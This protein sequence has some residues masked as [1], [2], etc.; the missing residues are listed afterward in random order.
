MRALQVDPKDN[1]AVVS[2]QT[3]AGETVQAGQTSLTAAEAVPAG[4]KI[5]LEDIPAGGMVVKYGV[6]IGRASRDIPAGSHVHSHN[7]EDITSQLCREYARAF[8]KKAG[9]L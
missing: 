2:R 5:A 8:K 9:A 3:A 4:H 6:P 7:V 1:V